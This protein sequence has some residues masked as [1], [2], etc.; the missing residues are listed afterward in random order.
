M[1]TVA[2]VKKAARIQH[3]LSID[4]SSIALVWQL[5]EEH[6]GLMTENKALRQ[7]LSRFKHNG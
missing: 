4:W 6:D 1:A 5:T 2:L 7:R 3:D